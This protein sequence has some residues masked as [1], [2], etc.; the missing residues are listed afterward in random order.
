MVC[1]LLC[2]C[3]ADDGGGGGGVSRLELGTGRTT[4]MP[5]GGNIELVMGPQGG[6]HLD[7]TL[8]I[9]SDAPDGLVLDYDVRRGGDGTTVS[10]PTQYVVESERLIA[11]ADHWLRLGDRAILDIAAPDEIVGDDV[12][13]GVAV[14]GG[15][16]DSR[17]A[18]VI[19]VE[20]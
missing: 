17:N 1:L 13:I 10:H 9:W 15:A 7:L 14:S 16:S 19:D 4:F 5:L 18:A 20:P 2:A 11:E 3:G 12:V 8:R 6:W